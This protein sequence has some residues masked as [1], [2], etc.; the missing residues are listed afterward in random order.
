VLVGI[1]LLVGFAAIGAMLANYFASRRDV[2]PWSG[3][4]EDTPTPTASSA[5]GFAPGAVASVT[6]SAT[7]LPPTLTPTLSPSATATLAAPRVFD[8]FACQE[9]C[10]E[11]GS[12]ALTLFPEKT[13]RIFLRWQFE[14]I[15]EG[16]LYVRRWTLL[17]MEWVHYEC[18]WPGPR[19][20]VVEISLVEPLGLRSGSW[21]VTISVDG[22]ELLSE[23]IVVEGSWEYWN[24]PGAFN[25]CYGQ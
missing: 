16:S 15:P 25:T 3:L 24:P 7:Y 22:V 6:P 10:E 13:T 14:N 12:N 18:T 1:V 9:P 2:S 20:G 5:A 8:F 17:D 19:D 11:D 23:T 4:S 21:T